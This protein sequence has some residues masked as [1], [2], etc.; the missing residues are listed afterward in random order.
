[1][2]PSEGTAAAS[3]PS[4]RC[5][6]LVLSAHGARGA[7]D[8]LLGQDRFAHPVSNRVV[9]LLQA[10]R[11]ST[12]RSVVVPLIIRVRISNEDPVLGRHKLIDRSKQTE[13]QGGNAEKGERECNKKE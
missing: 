1:M 12:F 3:P 8:A 5:V 4:M 7:G 10:C 13:G 2:P 6:S 11:Q 9:C